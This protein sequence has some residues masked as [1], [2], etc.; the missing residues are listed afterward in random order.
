M[1]RT[2][3]QKLKSWLAD[4]GYP[5]EM[6]VAQSLKRA[7]FMVAQSE[8]LQDS[9]TGKW[10]EADVVA[11]AE[12]R[13]ETCRAVFAVVV[14]CKSEKSKPWVLFTNKD[15]YPASLSVSRRA[16]SA[17]GK[18][19]LNVLA[20]RDE[21]KDSPLFRLPERTGYGVTTALRS[22]NKDL[23][24][25]VLLSVGKAAMGIVKRLSTVP[26][27]NL[28]PFAW[29]VIVI[30]APLFE[31]YL[32]DDGDF[33]LSAIERGLLIWRN[34]I[35]GRHTLIEIFRKDRFEADAPNLRKQA[36]KFTAA[37]AAENDRAPRED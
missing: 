33:Q 23:A 30:E 28:I 18:S 1:E 25:G 8:Y 9:D 36:L 6:E 20:L 31:S 34:P 27:D 14:E 22:D 4:H 13:G 21:V 17:R 24:Y 37:A 29:P 26:G 15:D 12:S 35:I 19:I 11:Y 32:D 16:T 7:G 2:F 3:E 5:L 10:R